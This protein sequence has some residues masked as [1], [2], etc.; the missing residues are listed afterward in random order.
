MGLKWRTV[1]FQ[2][3]R[4]REAREAMREH[5]RPVSQERFA[6]LL[7]V[8]RR[9][10]GRW[11][12]GASAPHL[13]QLTR[14]AELTDRSVAWLLG[15]DSI[16]GSTLISGGQV[17]LADALTHMAEALLVA[18]QAARDSASTSPVAA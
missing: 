4:L 15:E 13:K 8:S 9:S 16:S 10:S 18:A 2:P 12:T 17:P 5:G 3:K 6:E 1:A 7:G 14:I 11:E